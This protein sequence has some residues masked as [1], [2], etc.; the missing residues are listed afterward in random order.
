MYNPRNS[1]D[2]KGLS[3]SDAPSVPGKLPDPDSNERRLE[4]WGE[5][6]TYLRRDIRTVQRWEHD[7]GL[8]VRRLVIGKMGQV[9]AYR[10]ELDAWVRKRQ[11]IA[12][13]EVVRGETEAQEKHVPSKSPEESPAP[14]SPQERPKAWWKVSVLGLLLL[15]SLGWLTPVHDWSHAAGFLPQKKYMLIGLRFAS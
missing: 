5:I 9:Y 14:E 6:A 13:D 4:S 8:P 12:G 7:Y 3:V 2:G 1:K 11:P 15:A 10:S